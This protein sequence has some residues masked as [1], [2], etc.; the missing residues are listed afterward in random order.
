[1]MTLYGSTCQKGRRQ[2]KRNARISEVKVAMPTDVLPL[3]L[4]P[5]SCPFPSVNQALRYVMPRDAEPHLPQYFNT[6]NSSQGNGLRK[7]QLAVI[8]NLLVYFAGV[9]F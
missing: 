6:C 2:H 5:R 4:K 8:Q 9:I 1:M 7:V 3:N